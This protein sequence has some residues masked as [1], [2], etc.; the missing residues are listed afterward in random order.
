MY[1]PCR[2]KMS[3]ELGDPRGSWGWKVGDGVLAEVQ[4]RGMTM[5]ERYMVSEAAVHRRDRGAVEGDGESEM[6]GIDIGGIADDR[7]I[8]ARS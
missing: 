3:G 6:G 5:T 2:M 8:W 7:Y 4:L 1:D